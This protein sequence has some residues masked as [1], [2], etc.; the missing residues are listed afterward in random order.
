[1]K[2]L[3]FIPFKELNTEGVS[4]RILYILIGLVALVFAAFYLIGYGTPYEEDPSFNAPLFTD[5][6]IYFMIL[7][8]IATIA[9]SVWSVIRSVKNRSKSDDI[10]N[11][12]PA[13][14]ITLYTVVLLVASF[15][16][17]FIFG[18]STPLKINGGMYNNTFWLKFTDMF[19]NTSIIMLLAAVGCV[20]YG[21]TRYNRKMKNKEERK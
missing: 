12:V 4:S 8:I 18:S 20:V 19:V 7:L 3:K 6:L 5:V 9:V 14:K 16:I 1:M 17:T 11:G 13:S 2:K 15:L 10:T 21:M